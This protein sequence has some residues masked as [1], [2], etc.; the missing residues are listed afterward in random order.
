MLGTGVHGPVVA[1]NVPEFGGICAVKSFG[2]DTFGMSDEECNINT[3]W[4]WK[5]EKLAHVFCVD[6]TTRTMY[7][8]KYDS[9]LLQH[10]CRSKNRPLYK[11]SRG[12]LEALS[13]FDQCVAIVATVHSHLY[14]LNDIKLENFL[15]KD[16]VVYLCDVG[17]MCPGIKVEG[18]K[19]RNTPAY[20]SFQNKQCF[21]CSLDVSAL[22]MCLLVMLFN[23]Y[24][25]GAETPRKH[26]QTPRTKLF[27]LR[28]QYPGKP[29]FS[30][31]KKEHEKFASYLPECI[32]TILNKI[33]VLKDCKRIDADDLLVLVAEAKKIL[34]KKVQEEEA[35]ERKEVKEEEDVKRNF[36]PSIPVV[37]SPLYTPVHAELSMEPLVN[38]DDGC[39]SLQEVSRLMDDY[40]N[41]T[42]SHPQ[43]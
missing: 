7:M 1:K 17:L 11:S 20:L 37:V 43:P 5:V 35:K 2:K 6:P 24:F 34:E 9:D 40:L 28:S 23:V 33:F 36:P 25:F 16:G 10:V 12:Q 22:G 41:Y 26:V 29:F 3:I 32:Q 19:I 39:I 38:H 30:L 14:T 27:R 13:L 21:P 8:K 15:V 31:F 42:A 4:S 18:R